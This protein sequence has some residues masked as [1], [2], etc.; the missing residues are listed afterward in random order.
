MKMDVLVSRKLATRGNEDTCAY[1][2]LYGRLECLKYARENGCPWNALTCH[3]AAQNG[4]I[5]CLKY[6]RENGC[7]CL[8]SFEK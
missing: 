1:A 7:P 8:S 5:E 4:H 6:A 3:Y 2:A